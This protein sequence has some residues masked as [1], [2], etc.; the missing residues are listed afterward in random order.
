[1]VVAVERAQGRWAALAAIAIGVAALWW[2]FV[3]LR[4][5]QLFADTPTSKC[6]GVFLGWNEVAGRAYA[7]R[8]T[9]SHFTRLPCVWWTYTV[10]EEVRS[11]RTVTT[12]DGDGHTSSHT[13]TTYSWRTI[14][15][16]HDDVGEFVL[17]DD[18]GSVAVTIGGRI[19]PRTV[20]SR[21]LGKRRWFLDGP[22]GVTRE[23]EEVIAVGDDLF[24][25]G[26]A[27]LPAGRAAPVVGRGDGGPNVISTRDERAVSRGYGWGGG[28]VALLAVAVIAFGVAV[29]V[30]PDRPGDARAWVP[31]V[32]AA[33]GVFFVAW[34][35]L[36]YNRIVRVRNRAQRAWSLIDVMLQRR[37]DLIGSLVAV[38]A[39]GAAHER[40][41]QEHLAALR[42][43]R[44]SDV[45]AAGEV[46]ASQTSVAAAAV[47]VAEA[48]PSLHADVQYLALQRSLADAED[49]IAM[50]REF[51]NASVTELRNRAR[52]FPG[53]LFARLVG[54]TD[55][56][57][58]A[59]GGFV[60]SVPHVAIE[61]PVPAPPASPPSPA[62]ATGS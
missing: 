5:R 30:R 56:P 27:T 59:P 52:T 26:E 4:K 35:T 33:L 7:E 29:A 55:L 57:L 49:R 37:H 14:D 43:P 8:P 32:A 48:N 54:R 13:E 50:S 28:L 46:S 40:P 6:A 3:L 22:T 17:V 20:W 31:G 41:L 11:T 45:A 61:I 44:G 39:A 53:M 42:A 24:V 47:A 21:D 10:E 2:A 23:T 62:P 9:I 34:L 16:G 58:F 36:A 51:Y 60:R 38:V 15:H 1:M 25:C 18:S 19:E 12:T